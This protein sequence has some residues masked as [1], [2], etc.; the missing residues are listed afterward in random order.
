MSML[1]SHFIGTKKCGTDA[2]KHMLR[3]H[4]NLSVADGEAGFFTSQYTKGLPW[5]LSL[6]HPSGPDQVSIEGTP[7]YLFD[8]QAPLRV[9]WMNP[10]MKLILIVRD[11]V[12]RLESEFVLHCFWQDQSGHTTPR[13]LE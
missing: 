2:L 9:K 10:K 7:G 12:K 8:P 1:K 4:P 5:Y 6:M 3:V 13:Q 11:P